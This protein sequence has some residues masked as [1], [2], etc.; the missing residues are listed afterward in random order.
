MPE[1]LRVFLALAIG[2][3]ARPEALLQLTRF[4][5]D[6]DRGTINLNPPGRIQTKKRRP[7]LP[8]PNWLRPW[9]EA[10]DGPLIA[11]RGKPV[12][13]IAGA[14]QTMRDAAALGPD[15]TAY[16]IRHTIGTELAARGVPELEIAALMGHRMP[17][18]QTTGR[19]LHVA[20][21]RLMS[22]R[23]ALDEIASE[24]GRAATRPISPETS[25]RASCVLLPKPRELL[26]PWKDGAGDGIRTHDPN[27][28][29]VGP[30]GC[31][32][33]CEFVTL[34]RSPLS[35]GVSSLPRCDFSC[36]YLRNSA[37]QVLP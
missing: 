36:A 32:G 28:G 31:E 9:I 2:T 34:P 13:K 26:T 25:V 8:M 6:L 24:I 16:T 15:V 18:S 20:P 21:E 22:A 33:L 27:L 23:K 1:H 7:I 12:R 5:C 19:Y 4:Q 29:K 11:W 3:A 30:S 37:T 10:S 35:M 17:N 14:F